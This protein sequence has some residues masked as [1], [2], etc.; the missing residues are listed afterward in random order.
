MMD[1][2]KSLRLPGRWE[3]SRGRSDVKVLWKVYIGISE[4]QFYGRGTFYGLETG[5]V[6]DCFG[7]NRAIVG[8]IRNKWSEI[9]ARRHVLRVP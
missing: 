1:D 5:G 2:K 7:W 9:C 8:E 3:A 6:A 4:Q